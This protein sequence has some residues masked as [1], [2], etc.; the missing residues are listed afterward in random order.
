M[1]GTIPRRLYRLNFVV[2]WTNA[3]ELSLPP[4][5]AKCLQ[6]LDERTGGEEF[7]LNR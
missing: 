3:P 5:N 1:H 4:I 6:V 2:S 7:E